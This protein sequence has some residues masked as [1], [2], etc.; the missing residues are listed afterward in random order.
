MKHKGLLSSWAQ[1][2]RNAQS[3]LKGQAGFTLV[4][5]A[6]VLVIIGLILGAVLKGQ[7]L[8]ENAKAKRAANDLNSFVAAYYSY[9]DRYGR[10]PGD[11]GPIGTLTARDGNWSVVTLA[12]DN[13]G[14]LA[15]TAAQTFT[16]GGEGAAFWQHVR[17]AGFITGDPSLTG[18]EALPKNSFGGLTGITS[19][20][21]MGGLTGIKVCMSQVPG[22]SAAALDSQLDDGNPGTG[23]LRVT[24]GAAGVN[25]APGAAAAAPYHESNVYT[26][27]RTM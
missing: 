7:E 20:P 19:D 8:I 13:N 10:I 25:T 15:V 24:M 22:K 16:G 3:G 27:C 18:V 6:I 9:I 12:G 11:D 5:M 2:R 21:V 4:E 17:A 14:A 23:T 26:I 1:V